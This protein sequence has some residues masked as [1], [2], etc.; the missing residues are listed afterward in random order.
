LQLAAGRR[1]FGADSFVLQI[2]KRAQMFDSRR[3][4]TGIFHNAVGNADFFGDQGVVVELEGL[5]RAGQIVEFAARGS[6]RN[7]L[8]DQGI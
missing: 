1:I 6:G 3:H 5:A 8:F 7:S 2:P 4:E